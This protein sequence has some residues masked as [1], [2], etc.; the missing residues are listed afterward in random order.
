MDVS[1]TRIGHKIRKLRELRNF[2]QSHIAEQLG[3]TQGAYSRLEVG[4]SELSY[5][6]LE[7]ISEVLE[8]PLAGIVS[9]NENMIFNISH[10]QTGNEYVEYTGLG[11]NERKLLQD[12]IELLRS[13]NTYLKRLLE[14]YITS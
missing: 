5:T 9:F 7:K 11:E 6:K 14:R 8:V 10:N 13:E 4:E 12:Q 2:T 3:I 1:A